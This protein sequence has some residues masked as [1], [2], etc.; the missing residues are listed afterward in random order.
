MHFTSVTS[1]LASGL[2]S[3]DILHGLEIFSRVNEPALPEA[4][5]LCKIGWAHFFL[6]FLPTSR[7]LHFLDPDCFFPP[8]AL[9]AALLVGSARYFA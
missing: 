3:G 9:P 2:F 8:L 5:H 1:F 6:F 7:S 4:R